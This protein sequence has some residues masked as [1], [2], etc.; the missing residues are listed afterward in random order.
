MSRM[1]MIKGIEGHSYSDPLI[2]PIVENASHE[3]ELVE[4]VSEAVLYT[5]IYIYI[6]IPSITLFC[7]SNLFAY[8]KC[9]RD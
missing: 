3:A 5:H 7:F 6:C 2:V 8:Q 9:F 4:S 1:E